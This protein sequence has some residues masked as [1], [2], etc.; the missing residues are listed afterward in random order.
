MNVTRIG[1]I[2]DT[3]G[4]SDPAVLLHFAGVDCIIHAGDVGNH[5]GEQG[6]EQTN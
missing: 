1:L 5:G 2:S 4:V 6:K 3:H